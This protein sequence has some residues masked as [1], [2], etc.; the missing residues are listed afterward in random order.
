[1]FL[2]TQKPLKKYQPSNLTV[3]TYILVLVIWISIQTKSCYESTPYPNSYLQKINH[4][5]QPKIAGIF[6]FSFFPQFS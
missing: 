1:M 2:P 3:G 6:S 4:L 5:P